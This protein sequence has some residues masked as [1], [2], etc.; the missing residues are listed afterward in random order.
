MV[1][2][3][4]VEMEVQVMPLLV[5]PVEPVRVDELVDYCM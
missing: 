4:I 5:E 3:E 1:L 2:L